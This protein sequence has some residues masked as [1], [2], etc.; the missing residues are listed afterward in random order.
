MAIRCL[1]EERGLYLRM[2]DAV[3]TQDIID[4][5]LELM[6][7]ERADEIRYVI[8]D[9]TDVRHVVIKQENISHIVSFYKV[10]AR[11][12]DRLSKAIILPPDENQETLLKQVQIR[13]NE[14]LPWRTHVFKSETEARSWL[15]QE[16]K[17][18]I[19]ASP[20]TNPNFL[21]ECTKKHINR[22]Y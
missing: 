13:M 5:V 19:P 9:W 3:T 1:W 17:F 21:T 20:K 18:D 4:S 12:N 6:G 10:A 22:R 11:T 7:H 8:D 15:S 14:Q 2:T 16:L